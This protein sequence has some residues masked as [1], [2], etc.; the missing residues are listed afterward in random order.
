MQKNTMKVVMGSPGTG[1][2]ERV[3][4]DAIQYIKQN[5]SVYI[6][7]PTQLSRQNLMHRIQKLINRDGH[8]HITSNKRWLLTLNNLLRSV[9][10]QGHQ[11]KHQDVVLVDESSMIDMMSFDSILWNSRDTH[12]EI[13]LYGDILQ[14]PISGGQSLLETLLRYNNKRNNFWEWVRVLYKDNTRITL[15]T[16][17]RWNINPNVSLEILTTNY[18]LNQLGLLGYDE[19]YMNILFRNAVDRSNEYGSYDGD[20]LNALD[21]YYLII[22]PTHSRGREVNSI[23]TNTLKKESRV[24]MPF[25]KIGKNTYL[26]PYHKDPVKLREMFPFIQSL[27][28]NKELSGGVLSGYVTAHAVQ[29]ATVDNAVFYFGNADIPKNKFKYHYTH[30]LLYTSISRSRNPTLLIGNTKEIRKMQSINPTSMQSRYEYRIAELAINKTFEVLFNNQEHVYTED[31]MYQVYMDCFNTM[32]V[33]SEDGESLAYYQV[34]S[35]P[36]SLEQVLTKFK[37]YNYVSNGQF[38]I[39]YRDRFYNKHK[40]QV[41]YTKNQK[42]SAG[43]KGNINARGHKGHTKNR[44]NGKVQLWLKSLDKNKLNEV[45]D[46]IDKLSVRKFKT[47][48]DMNKTQVMKWLNL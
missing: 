11:Y 39:N 44:G 38:Y 46:D 28:D 40:E 43:M 37:D 23:I 10:V 32:N 42:I 4:E 48:H 24:N 29:G 27:T 18:R 6:M 8:N 19:K 2:S 3:I 16:P 15:N 1:K 25:M 17:E 22:A 7:T 45:K 36:F 35:S 14:L 21:N 33:D 47:K 9:H 12:V 5:K 34:M 30:N 26:N 13:V 20:V 31:E 41:I